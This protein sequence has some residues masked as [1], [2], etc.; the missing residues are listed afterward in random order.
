MA[1]R[2]D[3]SPRPDA[4]EAMT[5]GLDRRGFV[6]AGA[7]ALAAFGGARWLVTPALASDADTFLT[8]SGFLTDVPDLD[9]ALA[10]RAFGQLTQLDAGFPEKAA[11]LASAVTRSLAPSVDD[12]LAHPAS[13]DTALR[14]TMTTVVSVWYLGYTGTPIP[15]RAEDDTGF[16]TFT[17]ALMYRAT[18]DATVRPTYARDGLNYWVEPPAFVTAP[19]MPPGIRTWGRESPQGVGA[20]PTAT[21]EPPEAPGAE[22]PPA[23]QQQE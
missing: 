16:V 13:S 8:L 19:P 21:A 11:V 5:G 7:V 1:E 20:I 4:P 22:P 12:F 18:I 15:L 14:E 17:G 9:P 10:A 3:D 6:M 2:Q 23:A